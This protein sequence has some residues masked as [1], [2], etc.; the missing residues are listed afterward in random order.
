MAQLD[1]M[2]APACALRVP[3]AQGAKIFRMSAEYPDE[4][5]TPRVHRAPRI[6][7]YRKMLIY[8]RFWHPAMCYTI[9][10]VYDFIEREA[11]DDFRVPGAVEAF[12]AKVLAAFPIDETARA[13]F[14]R[15]NA[16]R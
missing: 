9:D 1:L 12:Q 3:A 8:E 16:P 7:E 10:E 6:P 5:S 13:N 15:F 14:E 2:T 4:I 11:P